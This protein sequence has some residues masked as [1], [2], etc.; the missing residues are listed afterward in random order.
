[1]SPPKL[2]TRF[3]F[4]G[5]TKYAAQEIRVRMRK[6]R[7]EI[8]GREGRPPFDE[9]LRLFQFFVRKEASGGILLLFATAAALI[10]ANSPWSEQYARFWSTS[11]AVGWGRLQLSGSLR[12]WIDDVLMTVFFFVVGLEI[13]REILVGLLSSPSRAA[14]PIAG[15][16]GGMLIPAGIYAFFNYGTPAARG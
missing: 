3:R 6:G 2:W 9:M 10:L 16:L 4:H 5:E 14:L 13:K 7:I 12:F 15:A 1:M 11:P 8:S